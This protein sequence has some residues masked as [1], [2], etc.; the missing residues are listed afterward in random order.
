ME[1]NYV[2]FVIVIIC[3]II[4]VSPKKSASGKRDAV[5]LAAA[6]GFTLAADFF[7]VL[8][9]NY[10]IGI[11]VFCFAHLAYILRFGGKKMLAFA[12][13]AIFAPAVYFA[14]SHNALNGI[15][16]IYAQLFILSYT[17]MVISIKKRKY[18]F[19]NNVLIVAGM[20]LFVLCDISVLIWNL[21]EGSG[22][23][24][25]FAIIAFNAIWLFYVPAQICLA[26]SAIDF[27]TGIQ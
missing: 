2:K 1:N 8:A 5:L 9:Q 15:A 18:P 23:A 19:E 16:L 27:R 22:N 12:P 13:I 11:L 6:L 21:S 14:V 3:F 7:L 26:M 25:G 17:S 10:R 24:H 4:A 20:T